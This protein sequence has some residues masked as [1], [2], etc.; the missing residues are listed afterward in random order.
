VEATAEPTEDGEA[1]ILNGEKLWCTNAPVA[2]VMVVMATTPPKPGKKRRPISA[3]I[4]E[5]AWEGVETTHRLEFMGLRGIEN[6][7][8][9]FKNVRVPK[10]NLLLER[11]Q[12]SQAG[13]GHP[14]YGPAHHPFHLR[15]RREVVHARRPGVRRRA[16]PVGRAGGQA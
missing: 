4:V 3:F 2:D 7:L 6:G 14:E 13:P 15:R 12:G 16:G 9:R 10:E 11:G 8:V 1:Y 5:N